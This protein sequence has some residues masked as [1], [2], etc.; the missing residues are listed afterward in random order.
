MTTK[1]ELVNWDSWG[2]T[3]VQ[4]QNS[5]YLVSRL[6]YP[7][8][9]V[10]GN[11]RVWIIAACASPEILTFL[12]WTK[13][14]KFLQRITTLFLTCLSHMVQVSLVSQYLVNSF[15]TSSQDSESA[16]SEQDSLLIQG[17]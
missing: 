12:C 17:L 14:Q 15:I 3:N 7:V 1:T 4:R 16:L 6:K 11:Y 8:F 13:T 9:S 2:R 5:G 10:W